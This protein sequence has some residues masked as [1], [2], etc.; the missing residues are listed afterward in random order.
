MAVKVV[1]GVEV[2]PR[3]GTCV[4]IDAMTDVVFEVGSGVGVAVT[5]D[6]SGEGLGS[7]VGVGV[8]SG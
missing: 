2:A 1:G 3:V 8:D 5:K 7:E 6:F 4:G